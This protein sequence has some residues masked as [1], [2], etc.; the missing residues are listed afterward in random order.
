M[1]GTTVT[2]QSQNGA[3]PTLTDVLNKADAAPQHKPEVNDN[4]RQQMTV[5]V[6]ASENQDPKQV[7]DETIGSARRNDIFNGNNS[8]YDIPEAG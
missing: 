5:N 1:P 2:A 7:A 3:W 4:R 6:Y 8:L